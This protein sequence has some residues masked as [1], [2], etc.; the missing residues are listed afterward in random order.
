MR[1]KPS[2]KRYVSFMISNS[3]S[4]CCL[5]MLE[6]LTRVLVLAAGLHV[7]LLLVLQADLIMMLALVS[8]AVLPFSW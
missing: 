8:L 7:W 3:A 1:R 6:V 5:Y 4:A 2:S